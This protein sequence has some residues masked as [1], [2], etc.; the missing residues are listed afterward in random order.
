MSR[1]QITNFGL[2]FQPRLNTAFPSA[3]PYT[4]LQA[5][6]L[7]GIAGSFTINLPTCAS[8]PG[9]VLSF[10]MTTA[11]NAVITPNG[12]ETID[13]AA[14]FILSGLGASLILQAS[15][16]TGTWRIISYVPTK[17]AFVLTDAA[18][19]AIDARNGGDP[20]VCDVTLA[21]NRTLG[22][23]TN[24]SDTRR[25]IIRVKQDGTGSRTL[26]YNAIYRFPSD[27]PSPTLSTAAGTTDIIAFMYNAASVK[28]DC[29]AAIM[30]YL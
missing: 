16:N 21:G 28:W 3:S 4:I 24:A 6:T 27:I 5:D 17:T 26:A 25:I 12:A 7:V 22:A 9:R 18:T 1:K 8:G 23:P 14:T 29:V 30:G 11:G 2:L 19:I 10:K 20:I 15:V 13:G